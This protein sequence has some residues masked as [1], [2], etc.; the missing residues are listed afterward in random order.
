[1]SRVTKYEWA[2]SHVWMSHGKHVNEPSDTYKCG[3]STYKCSMSHTNTHTHAHTHTCIVDSSTW[4]T[5]SL[6]SRY[7]YTRTHTHTHTHKHTYTHKHTHLHTNEVMWY[8]RVRHAHI[9]MR[10][11][12]SHVRSS[13]G[14]RMNESCGQTISFIYFPYRSQR[15]SSV[16]KNCNCLETPRFWGWFWSQRI[17]PD[18]GDQWLGPKHSESVQNLIPE[19][20]R[21]WNMLLNHFR[22]RI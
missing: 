12:T 7:S 6:S 21:P 10:H 5:A 1:M 3:M 17:P 22:A 11:V 19:L 4:H 13:H 8:V 16:A 9:L 2:K 15:S 14:T 18:K 20:T